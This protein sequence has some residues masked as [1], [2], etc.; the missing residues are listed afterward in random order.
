MTAVGQFPLRG[1]TLIRRVFFGIWRYEAQRERRG[2]FFNS[3]FHHSRKTIFF[4]FFGRFISYDDPTSH[5][6]ILLNRTIPSIDLHGGVLGD[7]DDLRG[8]TLR[9]HVRCGRIAGSDDDVGGGGGGGGGDRGHHRGIL[10]HILDYFFQVASFSSLLFFPQPSSFLHRPSFLHRSA[11]LH[12]RPPILH[13]HR[14][15]FRPPLSSGVV[16][17]TSLPAGVDSLHLGLGFA[18]RG[19]LRVRHEFHRLMGMM[20]AARGNGWGGG[21]RGDVLVDG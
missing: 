18:H 13:A 19:S 8:N 2:G 9:S 3:Q 15:M 20:V 6:R 7:H 5:S 21:G 11:F 12:V 4:F 10:G 1:R 17:T 16:F 14:P